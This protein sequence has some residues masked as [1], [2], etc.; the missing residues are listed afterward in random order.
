MIVVVVVVVVVGG[1]GC[2][3]GCGCG[4]M[5]LLVA[6]VVVIVVVTGW[7][8]YR[9]P[10]ERNYTTAAAISKCQPSRFSII[11]VM[12]RQRRRVEMLPQ[13]QSVHNTSTIKNKP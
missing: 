4:L 1:C 7:P 10:K 5:L 2:G 9:C 12:N 6:V 3:C 11:A 13:F 8:C